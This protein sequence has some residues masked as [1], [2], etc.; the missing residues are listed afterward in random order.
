M[1]NPNSVTVP[2]EWD[3]CVGRSSRHEAGAGQAARETLSTTL[4]PSTAGGTAEGERAEIK[5]FEINEDP[6]HIFDSYKCRCGQ[7]LCWVNPRL[8]NYQS[9]TIVTVPPSSP[10]L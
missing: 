10:L 4:T 5:L 3:R 9:P 6:A 7:M 1:A 2:A 8:P